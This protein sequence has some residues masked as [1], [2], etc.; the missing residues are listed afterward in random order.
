MQIHCGQ[1]R[2]S[3]K[4]IS[5]NGFWVH[6]YCA[7]T[8]ISAQSIVNRLSGEPSNYDTY[9]SRNET[10]GHTVIPLQV[11]LHIF[12]GAN[13][14]DLTAKPN[15]ILTDKQNIVGSLLVRTEP[16]MCM[17]IQFIKRA[18]PIPSPKTSREAS[19][20][21]IPLT[22]GVVPQRRRD[23]QVKR[24]FFLAEA[25]PEINYKCK[26]HNNKSGATKGSR[27]Q[28]SAGP[29]ELS[30]LITDFRREEK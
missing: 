16:Y 30:S 21:A 18:L 8:H 14:R 7:V 3:G 11:Y 12:R 13:I 17:E 25:F 15:A 1:L 10:K 19:G 27:L 20:L 24:N 9:L 26:I 23:A 2:N 29:P 28:T 6:T 22:A 4:D 5:F